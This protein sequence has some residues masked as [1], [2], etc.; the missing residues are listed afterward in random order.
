MQP[1]FP[2]MY[3][4]LS[5][6]FW[7]IWI[8]NSSMLF[9]DRI[10]WRHYQHQP[11]QY[12]PDVDK[13]CS[14]DTDWQVGHWSYHCHRTW[15]KVWQL[16]N[17]SLSTTGCYWSKLNII[18][19]YQVYYNTIH[20]LQ[21]FFS[22]GVEMSATDR[23]TVTSDN[24]LLRLLFMMVWDCLT[25]RLLSHEEVDSWAS[26]LLGEEQLKWNQCLNF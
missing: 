3:L 17:C 1:H 16:I 26:L 13:L 4:F 25:I 18:N 2:Y 10:I 12:P 23:Q 6:C 8:L 24:N 7:S 21:R 20:Y 11:G 22:N 19:K 5:K 14:I 15:V 9:F